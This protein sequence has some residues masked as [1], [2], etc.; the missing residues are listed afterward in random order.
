MSFQLKFN[1]VVA[2]S[3]VKVVAV[4][5]S[6][7]PDLTVNSVTVP[8]RYG[9]VPVPTGLGFKEFKISII[10]PKDYTH[11]DYYYVQEL[12]NWLVGDNYN[13]SKLVLDNSGTYYMAKVVDSGELQDNPTYYSSTITFRADDPR[14]Y[15]GTD[16]TKSI[17]SDGTAASYVTLN[18]TAKTVAFKIKYTGTIPTM[19]KFYVVFGAANTGFKIT[20]VTTGEKIIIN[21]SCSAGGSYTVIC[22]SKKVV[23]AGGSSLMNFIDL[24]STWLTLIKGDNTIVLNYNT[25]C[26]TTFNYRYNVIT[27]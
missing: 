2:P 22:S 24:S 26:P 20:N 16:T 19:P 23:G 6:P 1:N 3:F 5:Q 7:L 18:S 27:F 21:H 11:D 17:I 4:H 10:I 14:R 9:T 15:S 25:V 12:G 13:P 8:N